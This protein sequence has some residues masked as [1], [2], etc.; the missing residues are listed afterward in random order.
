MMFGD[1]P[2][3]IGNNGDKFAGLVFLWQIYFDRCSH[4]VMGLFGEYSTRRYLFLAQHFWFV[5]TLQVCVW[6]GGVVGRGV[7]WNYPEL[8]DPV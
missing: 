7:R 6:V 5:S 8:I 1:Y 2:Q 3:Y 4:G